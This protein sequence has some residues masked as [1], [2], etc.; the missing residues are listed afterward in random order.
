MH[1]STNN[2]RKRMKVAVTRCYHPTRIER[3]LLAQVFELASHGLNH[4]SDATGSGQLAPDRA[5]Q[6]T[7][8]DKLATPDAIDCCNPR[9]RQQERAA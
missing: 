1:S 7:T 6:G 4:R 5:S 2:E 9:N 8:E 3:E